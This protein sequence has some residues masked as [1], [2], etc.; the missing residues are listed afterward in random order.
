[1]IKDI[2]LSEIPEHKKL[3]KLASRL[4]ERQKDTLHVSTRENLLNQDMDI[5]S[6]GILRFA[7]GIGDA[8]GF[9]HL[10]D[11]L[12]YFTIKI[13]TPVQFGMLPSWQR[14]VQLQTA[15]SEE[16]RSSPK[17]Q[18]VSLKSPQG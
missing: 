10:F 12:I 3:A 16:L 9:S 13:N 11:S 4:H 8:I 15:S 6:L 7:A 5:V 2:L 18:I 14:S 17:Y 1:M